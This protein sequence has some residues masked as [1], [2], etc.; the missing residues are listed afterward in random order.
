[1]N[2]SKDQ[3]ELTIRIEVRQPGIGN[4]QGLT[5]TDNV[6]LRPKAFL[7]MCQILA[8]F[9]ELAEKIRKEQ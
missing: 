5:V 8:K 9:Q 6:I 4:F 2:E 1:M 7:E 3:L